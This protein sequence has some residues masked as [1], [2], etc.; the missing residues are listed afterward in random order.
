MIEKVERRIK[1]KEK[2]VFIEWE[3]KKMKKRL[4]IEYIKGGDDLLGKNMGGEKVEK[5]VRKG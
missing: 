1:R 5:N 2:I 3:K 4:K